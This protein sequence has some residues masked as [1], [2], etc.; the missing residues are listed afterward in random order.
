MM[1]SL[2]GVVQVLYTLST[3]AILGEG[4]GIV[5]P[6]LPISIF[7]PKEHVIAIATFKGGICCFRDL[8]RRRSLS[9]SHVFL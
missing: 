1:K 6:T 7:V 5:C 4:I 9:P 3:S 2:K 8:T